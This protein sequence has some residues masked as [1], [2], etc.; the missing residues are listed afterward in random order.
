MA[1]INTVKP[2]TAEGA[3]KAAYD[4]FLKNIGIIPRPMEMMSASPGLFELQLQRIEYFAKHPSLSFALQ[5]H[6]RYLVSY[7]L[8]YSFCLDFNEHILKKQGLQE[9][10]IRSIEIDPSRSLL[11][12]NENAMLVF[13][14]KAVKDPGSVTA[15]DIKS[16]KDLGWQD[17]DIVDALSH[18]VNMIDHS[19]MMRVFQMD[20]NC[21]PG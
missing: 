6:I 1:L 7:H 21:M 4:M 9:A 14:V 18:G 17:R 12:K 5:T 13:V 2:E 16:L 8:K 11:E 10:D 3:I 20:Q 15:D 19:M